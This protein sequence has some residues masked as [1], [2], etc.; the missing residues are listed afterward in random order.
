MRYQLSPDNT[1]ILRGPASATLLSGQ[2]TILGG[3]FRPHQK[4]IVATQ[5]QLPFETE[6]AAE[7][8]VDLYKSGKSFQLEGSTIPNS[9]RVAASTLEEMQSGS[10]I[11]LGAADVGK[12]TLCVYLVN[13]LK[14]KSRKL[15]VVDAD[16]GQTDLGP[17]TT[18]ARASPTQFIT[19]L[20]ELESDA[21]LFIGHT[22][23]GYVERKLIDGIKRLSAADEGSLTIINTDGWITEPGA[24]QFKIRLITEVDPTLSLGLAFADELQPILG[25]VHAPSVIVESAKAV[26]TRSRA[27]R[28]K[29]RENGYRRFLDRGTISVVQLKKVHF[30]GPPHFP[31][32]SATNR[33]ALRNLI[34]GILNEDGY[35]IQIGLLIDINRDSVHIYSRQW[36]DE[37]HR[38]ELGCLKL[39]TSGTEIAFL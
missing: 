6:T 9:W 31:S 37:I 28:R 15:R 26:L 13:K 3:P 17:P 12:S 2:A 16:I 18:I 38:I 4:T 29:I 21:R 24:I 22:S 14:P 35:L 20:T 11:I 34:I 10:V 23:P 33:V 39:T 7:L 1:L 19:S 25:S 5:R 30:S 27:D 32:V 8:E 36:A